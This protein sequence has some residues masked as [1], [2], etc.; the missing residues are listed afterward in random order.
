[1]PDKTVY[2]LGAGASAGSDFNLPVMKGFFREEDFT[3][4]GVYKNLRDYISSFRPKTELEDINLEE[5]IT[6]LELTSEGFNWGLFDPKLHETKIELY[7][8]IRFRLG[9]P[10]EKKI[11]SVD[12]NG[13]SRHCQ[14]HLEFIEKLN[15][16]NDSIISLNYDLIV[17]NILEIFLTKKTTPENNFN[18]FWQRYENLLR[19]PTVWGAPPITQHIG[20]KGKGVYVKLHGSLDWLYCPSQDCPHNR[21]FNRGLDPKEPCFHC[22]TGIET[23]IVP[24]TMK[25]SFEKFPKL[26]F[27][28]HVAFNKLKEADKIVVIGMSFP[29]SDYYLKW[30]VRQAMMVRRKTKPLELVIVNI[31]NASFEETVKKTEEIFMVCASGII[32]GGLK[33][34]T[35]KIKE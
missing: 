24:P 1:M 30:L 6:H 11:G 2:F 5:L 25:K 14:K 32:K 17:D 22:G 10:L 13:S 27:L 26:G 7:D 8:Y 12:E 20:D 3:G 28:W 9:D 35:D 31:D 19:M 21:C 4:N 16:D 33:G 34:Y 29:N 23:A 18:K 15:P